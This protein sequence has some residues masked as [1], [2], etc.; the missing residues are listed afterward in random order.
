MT[1]RASVSSK[2]PESPRARYLQR[3][4]RPND[5]DREPL[6][7]IASAVAAALHRH[8]GPAVRLAPGLPEVLHFPSSFL[9]R[10]RIDGHPEGVRHVFVKVRR[11]SKM[12]SVR[13]TTANP[14]LHA[15]MR[16]EYDSLRRLYRLFAD[17]AARGQR[18]VRPLAY[19]ESFHAI[20]LEEFAGDTLRET[21]LRDARRAALA[22]DPARL[23]NR[24]RATGRWLWRLHDAGRDDWEPVDTVT[25]PAE[26]VTPLLEGLQDCGVPALTTGDLARRFRLAAPYLGSVMR[27]TSA[28]DLTTD[29]VLCNARDEVAVI[30]VKLRPAPL[31]RDLALALAH[32]DTYRLQFLSRGSFLRHP[33]LRRYRAAM[34]DGYFGAAAAA[35]AT[36]AINWFCARTVLDKWLMYEQIIVAQTSPRRWLTRAAVLGMRGYFARLARSYLEA[37]TAAAT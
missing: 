24:A 12:T 9:I 3:A 4:Y 31:P 30:D 20:V 7:Q 10:F 14:S 16:A 27:G 25:L 15:R 35:D 13:E 5:E 37:E 8:H 34:L 23:A 6:A 1:N 36:A 29:N 26:E 21:L 18:A 17:G 19:L 11:T 32:P 28:E 22:A 2:R 33:A